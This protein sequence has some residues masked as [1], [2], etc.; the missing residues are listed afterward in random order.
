MNVNCD[1]C[2]TR[3]EFDEHQVPREGLAVQCSQCQSVFNVFAPSA[4][5][6]DQVWRLRQAD[7][8]FFEF[9]ELTTLQR[10]IV[11]RKVAR[12][13]EI[14]RTGNQWKR[15]GDIAELATFFQLVDQANTAQQPPAQFAQTPTPMPVA[16][17]PTTPNMP[18]APQPVPTAILP[19]QWT[20]GMQLQAYAPQPMGQSPSEVS[21]NTLNP[22]HPAPESSQPT[23]PQPAVM[24]GHAHVQGPETEATPDPVTPKRVELPEDN[25]GQ[26][27]SGVDP[28]HVVGSEIGRDFGDGFVDDLEHEIDHDPYAGFVEP[29][30]SH[31]GRWFFVLLLLAVLGGSAYVYTQEPELVPK[32]LYAWIQGMVS[33][34]DSTGAQ[35]SKKL[36]LEVERAY[37]ALYTNTSS[38]EER[39]KT[40]FEAALQENPEY[41]SAHLGLARVALAHA[42]SIRNR[43][44]LTQLSLE[45]QST[46]ASP[47]RAKKKKLLPTKNMISTASTPSG[48]AQELEKEANKFFSQALTT[49]KAELKKDPT[50]I[51]AML[52]RADLHRYL[53]GSTEASNLLDSISALQDPK[54]LRDLDINIEVAVLRALLAAE[55]AIRAVKEKTLKPN[56]YPRLFSDADDLL[57]AAKTLAAERATLYYTQAIVA[58]YAGQ[59]K[60]AHALLDTLLVMEPTHD[61][62]LWLK[63]FWPQTPETQAEPSANSTPAPKATAAL[64]FDQ[65]L[66]QAE[67]ARTR[68]NP[69]KAMKL[70]QQALEIN[71]N[72]ADALTSLGWCYVDLENTSAAIARFQQV[73]QRAPRFSDAHMGLAE[74]Y[75]LRGQK[76]QAIKHYKK[77]LDI[78]PSGPEASVARRMIK[79]LK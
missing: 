8:S 22:L 16:F 39:A 71:P 33:A 40:G 61:N 54:P 57:N 20:Q 19:N 6:N 24:H 64:S 35:T 32:P 17:T 11:E 12:D 37:A 53:G 43:S 76:S 74:A 26:E 27:F 45:H 28:A 72:D 59:D 14:S 78:L 75:N 10:W 69:H 67:R 9:K 48:A 29:V 77:Y 79:E 3:Y 55:T 18:L 60:T 50:N 63:T 70:L 65:L 36:Q 68:D 34:E 23:I 47:S 62:A 41:V 30:E 31:K 15:L 73:I 49:V 2:G 4:D 25:H 51:D 52:L 44:R 42:D 13:A 56:A 38:G 1:H 7:G 21:S 5:E 66:S 58:F 46:K